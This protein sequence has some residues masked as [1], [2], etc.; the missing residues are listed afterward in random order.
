MGE[1]VM[2]MHDNNPFQLY[3]WD[4]ATLLKERARHAKADAVHEGG[5]APFENGLVMGYYHVLTT[6]RSQALA[7]D[8]PLEDLNL[9]DI[10]PD[11]ELLQP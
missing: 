9:H 10:D 8:I 2:A 5:Q 4:L 6:M 7:F 1:L 11:S 3:L